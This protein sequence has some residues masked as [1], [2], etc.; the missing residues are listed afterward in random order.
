MRDENY[1]KN[2]KAKREGK[3]SVSN[4][5]GLNPLSILGFLG[6]LLVAGIVLSLLKK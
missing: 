2:K 4:T 3:D 6:G 1:Y 5:K